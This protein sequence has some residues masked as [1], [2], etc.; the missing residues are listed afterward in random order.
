M[1]RATFER[2]PIGDDVEPRCQ[3]SD[4][5]PRQDMMALNHAGIGAPEHTTETGYAP[6]PLANGARGAAE[7]CVRVFWPRKSAWQRHSEL[8]ASD[9]TERRKCRRGRHCNSQPW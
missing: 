4:G 1:E 9:P 5:S 8:T 6:E 3:P 7:L 2:Q